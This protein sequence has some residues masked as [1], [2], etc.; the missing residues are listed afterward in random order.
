M[1]TIEPYDLKSL[2]QARTHVAY[3]QGELK[4]LQK[5]NDALRSSAQP[6]RHAAAPPSTPDS[7]P[8]PFA[9]LDPSLES[10]YKARVTAAE[11]EV[12]KA[13]DAVLNAASPQEQTLAMR[14]LKLAEQKLQMQ[15][16]NFK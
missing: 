6:A 2:A 12:A 11:D 13:K 1:K 5:E 7:R 8:Q 14:S 10:R 3:L 4:R 9:P 15:R 16:S